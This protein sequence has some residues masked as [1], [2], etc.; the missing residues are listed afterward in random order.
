ML[1]NEEE[2][3]KTSKIKISTNQKIIKKN[4]NFKYYKGSLKNYKSYYNNDNDEEK[5]SLIEHQNI[6]NEYKNEL[7]FLNMK[8]KNEDSYENINNNTNGKPN[9]NQNIVICV[10]NK[11]LNQNGNQKNYELYKKD[12]KSSANINGNV[13]MKISKLH[14]FI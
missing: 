11:E 6:L 12:G 8:R 3:K 7:K 9:N 14:I 13:D 10:D 1:L 2:Q 4:N 5:I